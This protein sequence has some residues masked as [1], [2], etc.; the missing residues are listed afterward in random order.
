M[1]VCHITID[2]PRPEDEQAGSKFADPSVV[3]LW[4][5]MMRLESVRGAVVQN[6]VT[7][8]KLSVQGV[9]RDVPLDFVVIA[10]DTGQ[11]ALKSPWWAGS[12]QL[13]DSASKLLLQISAKP[14]GDDFRWSG[15]ITGPFVLHGP[16]SDGT[17]PV[18]D[19]KMAALYTGPLCNMPPVRVERQSLT[20]DMDAGSPAQTPRVTA[21]WHEAFTLT[22][23]FDKYEASDVKKRSRDAP[24]A[25]LPKPKGRRCGN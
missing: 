4:D 20:E 2:V 5:E 17:E 12:A 13:E 7:V 10:S 25:D 6:R 19:L 23:E 8:K 16:A 21:Y 3:S 11:H 15:S 18:M 14:D 1:P 9:S 22:V 24:A